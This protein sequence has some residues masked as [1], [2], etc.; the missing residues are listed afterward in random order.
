MMK[1]MKLASARIREPIQGNK[2]ARSS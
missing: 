1:A 2:V